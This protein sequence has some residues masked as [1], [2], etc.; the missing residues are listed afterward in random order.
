MS[1]A[2]IALLLVSST[3]PAP[4][5]STS[6]SEE[7]PKDLFVEAYFLEWTNPECGPPRIHAMSLNGKGQV[8]SREPI[9]C[10][11]S[12][13]ACASLTGRDPWVSKKTPPAPRLVLREELLSL[14]R[15]IR[16][17]EF[18]KIKFP[19]AEAIPA[20]HCGPSKHYLRIRMGGRTHQVG[21]S[22]YGKDKLP[23]K[24]QVYD[25]WQQVSRLSPTPLDAK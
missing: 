14:V 4:F 24:S 13:G 19:R 2:L 6:P 17:I 12:K 9:R 7:V 23:E 22:S 3:C 15:A 20:M 5:A 21:V 10:D 11:F 1:A 25:L 18:F 16:K 8:F